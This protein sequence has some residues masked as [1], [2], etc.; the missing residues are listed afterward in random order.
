MRIRIRSKDA[1]LFLPVPLCMAGL[2]IALTPER[3]FDNMQKSM[4]PA[5]QGALNKAAVRAMFRECYRVLKRYKGL[6]IIH[7]EA[8]DG[9][10]VSIRL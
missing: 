7:V 10:Y 3:V 4:P 1:N 2:A 9:T 8:S 5:T 6:E